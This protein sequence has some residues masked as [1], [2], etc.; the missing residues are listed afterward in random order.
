MAEKPR[1]LSKEEAPDP[2]NSYERSHPE[3]EAGM[4]RLN[5]NTR[6]TPTESVDQMPRTV[7]H[8]Q[9][10][11]RQ[12]NAHDNS[13]ISNAPAKSAAKDEPV[14]WQTKKPAAKKSKK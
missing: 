4:G 10:G 1:P 12:I 5:N 13:K 7:K 9:D 2:S 3:N 14:G 11:S 8:A 6:A